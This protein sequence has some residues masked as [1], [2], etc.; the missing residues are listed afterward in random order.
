MPA[1]YDAFTYC[2]ELE[3]L[4]IRLDH[5]KDE[6]DYFI[7]IE[8]D[9]TF[10]ANPK[11]LHYLH[12]H[13]DIVSEYADR[14]IYIKADLEDLNDPWQREY[15]QRDALAQIID[16]MPLDAAL[17]LSD[18]DE[19]PRELR[20]HSDLLWGN[21]SE[22]VELT[23]DTYFFAFNLLSPEVV[24]CTKGTLVS[25]FKGGQ[26]LRRHCETES[27]IVINNNSWHY[28]Y[29][30]DGNG[31]KNKIQNFSHF[32]LDS[33]VYTDPSGIE[34]RKARKSDPF[35]RYQL[36]HLDY[37]TLD[38]PKYITD[39]IDYFRDKGLLV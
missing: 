11:P 31:V 16:E 18:V 10:R 32:E 22:R 1:I 5:L 12:S 38:C 6:V 2:G 39:N 7:L 34:A 33:D 13:N 37:K 25:N 29:M 28:S 21:A 26:D 36:R 24:N 27:V 4:K 35:D 3:L 15:A 20:Q 30:F 23:V 9:L 14:I 19:I 8:S 17:W